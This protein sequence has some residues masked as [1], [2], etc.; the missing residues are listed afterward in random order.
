MWNAW[1]GLDKTINW[2]DEVIVSEAKQRKEKNAKNYNQL[3]D[4]AF[5]EIS[6]VL[7]PGKYFSM[8]FN[9]LDAVSY[10]HLDVYKRQALH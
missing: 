7:K 4:E 1:L 3:L 8:A 2:N 5:A 10:T 6:R 9:C